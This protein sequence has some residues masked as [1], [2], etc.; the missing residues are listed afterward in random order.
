MHKAGHLQLLA[1]AL[2]FAALLGVEARSAE[3]EGAL[4]YPPLSVGEDAQPP[5]S[6]RLSA[7]RCHASTSLG[8][9]P[10]SFTLTGTRTVGTCSVEAERWFKLAL[11]LITPNF[12]CLSPMTWSMWVAAAVLAICLGGL[13]VCFWDLLRKPPP[14]PW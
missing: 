9:L 14:P 13:V 12:G 8:R 1:A 4:Q 11:Y 5:R 6:D 2:A 3:I 7:R 10:S